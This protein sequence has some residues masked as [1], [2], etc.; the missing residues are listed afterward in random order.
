VIGF[1][2]PNAMR[3]LSAMHSTWRTVVMRSEGTSGHKL[4]AR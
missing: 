4:L 1:L 2:S 3:S